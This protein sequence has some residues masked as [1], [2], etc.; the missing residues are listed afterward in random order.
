MPYKNSADKTGRFLLT[1]LVLIALG[2][3]AVAGYTW[4]DLK[5]VKEEVRVT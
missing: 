4:Y 2:A 3:S 1:L 5:K